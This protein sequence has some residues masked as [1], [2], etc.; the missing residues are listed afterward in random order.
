ML[1]G[2]VSAIQHGATS[3]RVWRSERYPNVTSSGHHSSMDRQTVVRHLRLHHSRQG[4][5]VGVQVV[6]RNGILY[7]RGRSPMYDVTGRRDAPGAQKSRSSL[8]FYQQPRFRCLHGFK[9][10]GKSRSTV[11]HPT[12]IQL[13][14][15]RETWGQTWKTE[16]RCS[17]HLQSWTH[18]VS[19][20]VDRANSL[21]S[22]AAKDVLH[23]HHGLVFG[24]RLVRHDRGSR[25]RTP[26][27]AIA[28]WKVGVNA[29]S[30]A[31]CGGLYNRTPMEGSAR[32]RRY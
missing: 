12:C 29:R 1:P 6:L 11:S 23:H 10:S 17:S 2:T 21:I 16:Q 32:N 20:N 13:R 3:G 7:D 26:R 14:T 24:R 4:L 9:G 19:R 22:W 30:A 31:H 8:I 5:E 18:C 15:A 25:R 28:Q 27:F